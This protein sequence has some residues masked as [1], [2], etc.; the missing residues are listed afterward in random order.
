MFINKF[1]H[2]CEA[3]FIL[4]W[5]RYFRRISMLNFSKYGEKHLEKKKDSG[6][7]IASK[8][9]ELEILR[10]VTHQ[11]RNQHI[12]TCPCIKFQSIWKT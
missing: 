1:S 10:K 12:T 5:L 3:S 7:N 11:N 8:N 9:Y 6:K 4:L 2:S